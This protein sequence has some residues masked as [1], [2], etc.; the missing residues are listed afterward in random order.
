VRV[1]E[2]SNI[3]ST[4]NRIDGWWLGTI[5]RRVATSSDGHR[6]GRFAGVTE[7]NFPSISE[8]DKFEVIVISVDKDSPVV[9]ASIDITL[10]FVL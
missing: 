9:K 3:I 8:P 5:A 1:Y 2:Y 4:A 7:T 10:V 6:I